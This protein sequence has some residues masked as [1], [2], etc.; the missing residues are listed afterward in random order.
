MN[1]SCCFREKAL[2]AQNPLISSCPNPILKCIY[3]FQPL[4]TLSFSLF[5]PKKYKYLVLS[6]NLQFSQFYINQ[7]FSNQVHKILSLLAIPIPNPHPQTYL[8]LPVILEVDHKL[9]LMQIRSTLDLV[10][11][12]FKEELFNMS[13]YLY[14]CANWIFWCLETQILFCQQKWD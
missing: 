11:L 5:W 4:N 1:W 14:H 3:I 2:S 6:Q 13:L 9:I 10:L 7:H 12:L 8:F